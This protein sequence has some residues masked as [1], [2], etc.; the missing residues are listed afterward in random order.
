LP[1]F[2]ISKLNKFNCLNFT[3]NP[4]HSLAFICLCHCLCSSFSRLRLFHVPFK[5][6]TK[7]PVRISLV[8]LYFVLPTLNKHNFSPLIFIYYC[9]IFR[10]L[11]SG[12]LNY[13][14]KEI[15]SHFPV[16]FPPMMNCNDMKNVRLHNNEK[17]KE[18][19][20]FFPRKLKMFPCSAINS[21]PVLSFQI[22]CPFKERLKKDAEEKGDPSLK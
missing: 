22:F 5:Y 12:G 18:G 9:N 7:Q 8:L 19:K 14:I 17:K 11:L 16:T 1:K 10:A 20:K 2:L 3:S 13:V 21:T 6:H 15:P 4:N